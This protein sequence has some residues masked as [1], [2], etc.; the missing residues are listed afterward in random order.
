MVNEVNDI[1]KFGY[2]FFSTHGIDFTHDKLTQWW[3]ALSVHYCHGPHARYVKLWVVHAA[4][5]PGTFS[6]PPW[7]SDPVIHHGTCVTHAV[8]H[9]GIAN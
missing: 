5:M 1:L 9:A 2:F 8:M 6:P 3:S 4:G 7:F